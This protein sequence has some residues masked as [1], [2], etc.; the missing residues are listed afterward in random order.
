MRLLGR[1]RGHRRPIGDAPLVLQ[2]LAERKRG[3]PRPDCGERPRVDEA[4]LSLGSDEGRVGVGLPASHRHLVGEPLREHG[5][6]PARDRLLFVRGVRALIPLLG[7]LAHVLRRGCRAV[8]LRVACPAGR[9]EQQQE[10]LLGALVTVESVVAV[11]PSLDLQVAHARTL[12]SVCR[13][14]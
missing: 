8:D 14:G 5:V 11:A 13:I 10:A 9:L 6:A 12:A 2:R 7:A 4:H 3:V 1:D